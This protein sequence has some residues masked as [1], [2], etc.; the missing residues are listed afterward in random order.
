MSV[1]DGRRIQ[2][3][4]D[5]IEPVDT[6]LRTCQGYHYDTSQVK[7]C[8]YNPYR[9]SESSGTNCHNSCEL[10][11]FVTSVLYRILM[12][13]RSMMMLAMTSHH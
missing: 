6:G 13:I 11:R 12:L 2:S 5:A 4:E 1:D 3:M 9:K 7:G 8:R 10:V